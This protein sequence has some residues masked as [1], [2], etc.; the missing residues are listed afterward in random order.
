ME[1]TAVT[2]DLVERL[3]ARQHDD[4]ADE[5]VI[6]VG[7]G[8]DNA[9]FRVGQDL[10]ARLPIRPEGAALVE[11]E[12]RYL[13]AL[14]PRLPLPISQPLRVGDPGDGYPWRWTIVPWFVGGLASTEPFDPGHAARD[15]G[16]FLAALAH[17]AP[18]DAPVNPYRGVPL[19]ARDVTTRLRIE[20]L[21]DRINGRAVLDCWTHALDAPIWHGPPVWVHG[22]L[23]PANVIVR[24][25]RI[26][27]V[28]DFGDLNGGDPAADLAAAW[29]FFGNPVDRSMMRS[30]HGPVDEATWIRARANALAHGIA[31]LNGP[32]TDLRIQ[33]IG[34][35]TIANVV[36]DWEASSR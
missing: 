1:S 12:V 34:Q 13:P 16:A 30:A 31:C 25:G 5:S 18:D 8:W 35:H 9:V 19:A 15:L 24:S 10:A 33:A 22:D 3:I 20:R 36:A 4:L 2:V 14:A 29:M 26:A 27:A 17:A 32:A 28:I 7:R 6:E 11:T 21:G 23:H